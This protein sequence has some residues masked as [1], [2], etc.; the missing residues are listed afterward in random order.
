MKFF[1]TETGD[2]VT[3]NGVCLGDY[4]E[5]FFYDTVQFDT[6]KTV[7]GNFSVRIMHSL[8][9]NDDF[10]EDAQMVVTTWAALKTYLDALSSTKMNCLSVRPNQVVKVN[11]RK[12]TV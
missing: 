7:T 10:Q 12:V 1:L 3:D 6:G 4:L 11:H 2:F 5:V 9:H 8:V